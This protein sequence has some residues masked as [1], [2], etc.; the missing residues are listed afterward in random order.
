MG[1]RLNHQVGADSWRNLI[2]NWGLSHDDAV[3]K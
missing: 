1:G 2:D 3:A